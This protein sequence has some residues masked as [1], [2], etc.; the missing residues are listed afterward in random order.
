M[1]GCVGGS[2]SRRRDGRCGGRCGALGLA[3]CSGA[4]PEPTGPQGI[5]ATITT[6][7]ASPTAAPRPA[8]TSS[9][10]TAAATGWY[11]ALG[12]S[13]AAGYQPPG[14]DQKTR[15]YAGPVLEGVRKTQ[16]GTQLT[17][18]GCSGETTTSMLRGGLCRYPEGSQIAAAVA[19]L[20]ANAATT[21]L[22][23]LDMGA[24]N[25]LQ[26]AA[27]LGRPGLRDEHHDDRRASELATI[28]GQ[29]RA[30]APSVTDR[31]ADV[32]Q[33]AARRVAEGPEGRTPPRSRSL[34]WPG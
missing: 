20:K 28:L 11:L 4:A 34:S 16:P 8:P 31:R 18:L 21:R 26:C 32:L 27:R 24:N 7:P 10:Q 19:F 33:P 22:V 6:P 17:N 3:G 14:G 15:G 5:V 9:D 25:V 12:D 23:T 2:T 30:A 29:I 1:A 13:L